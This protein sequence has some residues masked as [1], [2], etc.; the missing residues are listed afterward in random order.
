VSAR[1]R[2]AALWGAVGVFVVATLGLALPVFGVERP[3]LVLIGVAALGAGVGAGVVSYVFEHR[4]AARG[5]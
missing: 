2:S 4:L 5:R 3:S 1:R